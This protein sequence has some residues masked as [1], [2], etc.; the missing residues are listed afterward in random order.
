MTKIQEETW[1]SITGFNYTISSLG[2]IKNSKGEI[3]KPSHWNAYPR[4][5]LYKDSKRHFFQ[6]HRLVAL[7]FIPNPENKPCACH[8]DNDPSNPAADNLYWGTHSENNIQA[9]KEGRRKNKKGILRPDLAGQRSPR[10]KFTDIQVSVIKH[11]ICRGHSLGSIA[12]YFKVTRGTIWKIKAN[13]SWRYALS[14]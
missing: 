7:E 10:S 5:K 2:T 3:I 1:K 9:I 13:Y 8:K 6:V 11:A 4:I 12:R 14:P